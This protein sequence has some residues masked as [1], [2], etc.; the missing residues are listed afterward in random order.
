M[1]I[2]ADNREELRT[3][4][5]NLS[6][7]DDAL[8]N[9]LLYYEGDVVPPNFDEQQR[10]AIW[11]RALIRPTER[12]EEYMGGDYQQLATLDFEIGSPR[13]AASRRDAIADALDERFTNSHVGS[14][15]VESP[16][17]R[18]EPDQTAARTWYSTELSFDA[19]WDVEL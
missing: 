7:N 16:R 15:V 13:E 17:S 4:M 8:R 2:L 10:S 1:G 18:G 3:A 11:I 6:Q 9:T 12:G 14:M 19:W 5:F